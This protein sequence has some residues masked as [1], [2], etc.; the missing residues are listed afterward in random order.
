[1]SYGRNDTLTTP[2]L[3]SYA[4]QQANIKSIWHDPD[5]AQAGATYQ[6]GGFIY[7]GSPAQFQGIKVIDR[8]VSFH[9]TDGEE[10]SFPLAEVR[11]VITERPLAREELS[12]E[13]LEEFDA[14]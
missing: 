4:L 12:P 14:R 6:G 3:I 7:E 10:R 2:H 8:I 9:W 5:Q 13:A 11:R 1:M